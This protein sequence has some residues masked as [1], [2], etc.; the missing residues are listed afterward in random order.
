M[1]VKELIKELE[2]VE[3]KEIEVY[4]Y[5]NETSDIDHIESVDYDVTDRIDLNIK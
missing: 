4:A 1:T 3:N 2:R 5:N